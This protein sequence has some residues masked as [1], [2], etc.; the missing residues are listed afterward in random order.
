MTEPTAVVLGAARGIGAAVARRLSADGHT[1]IG[2]DRDPGVVGLFDD[3]GS[4]MGIIGD[5][6]D[7]ITVVDALRRAAETGPLTAL[8]HLAYRQPRTPLGPVSAADWADT[9]DVTSRSAWNAAVAFADVART[10][11]AA[12]VLT[13]SVQAFRPSGGSAAYAAA[14]AAVVSLTRSLAW[15][16]GPRGIRCNCVAPGYVAV[17]RNLAGRANAAGAA[18]I[19]GVNALGRI[20]APE[21]VAAAVG[22]LVGPAASAV[23]GVCLPVDAGELAGAGR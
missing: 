3:L 5:V 12:V 19:A 7:D 2:V 20:V 23:T 15:E 1:V 4:G 13:S 6:A 21:E 14:K 17:E 9:F 8:V 22:F 18:R 10:P 16:L 11:G